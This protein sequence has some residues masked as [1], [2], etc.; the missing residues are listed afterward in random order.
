MYAF[1]VLNNVQEFDMK[2]LS[3][4]LLSDTVISR[5]KALKMTQADL[6]KR[7][8]MNRSM[9]S[10]LE[11][12]DYTPSIDQLQALGECL[13]FEPT[14]LFL[15]SETHPITERKENTAIVTNTVSSKARTTE[16]T[17]PTGSAVATT[18]APGSPYNIAAAGTGSPYNI[19]VAGT[20]YVGLSLAV[21]L[22]QHNSVTAV[23]IIPEKVEKINNFESPI[24]DDYIEKFLRE[25]KKGTRKLNLHAT[26]DGASAYRNADFVIVAAPTNYDPKKNFFDCSA[27]ESVIRL[28]QESTKDNSV[29]H[30]PTIII[31]S[32]IPV[33]Y[34]RHIREKLGAD[35]ILFSPEFLRE[36]KAL[37]D[38]LY[39]SRIIV[40]YDEASDY[41]REKAHTFASLLQQGA[42]KENID[43]LFMGF[44]EAEAT[45]LFV[46]TYLA[47]RV[48]YF[49]E[50]D[51]YAEVKGLDTAQIIK[52]VCLDPRVGDY[53]NNPSFGYGGYCLPKDTKQLLAN[54]QDVPENL[55]EAIVQA[56]R[57]RKDFIADRVLEIAGTYGNSEDYSSAK[58]SQQ[59]DIV[60]GVYRLT[61]KANSDNFRQSSI[62]GVMKRI[63]A[64]GATVVIYE[65]TLENGTTFFGSKVV[66]NLKKF[67]SMCGCIIA[68]RYDPALDDVKDK[69]YTRDLFRR[70]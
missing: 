11:T 24:K 42:Y 21:L 28:V 5:R 35:N 2:K 31:K 69:V 37:Y 53:Y 1:V 7:T 13:G 46:N 19:A 3:I 36:S 43:T 38:N 67:K 30:K 18:A 41:S 47:L 55:I 25:A 54:Y 23:D 9:L 6:A 16:G 70:D 10:K 45:K 4:S 61:M 66:N 50:L 20:G 17:L 59:K 56:N 22:S 12:Q 63:K 8:G 14:E 44:T 29:D 15:D 32:T 60:V 57:T 26:T 62:Q 27:V 34:T 48:S 51:T 58:E 33:G 39:P 68:N 65:P 64:K 52:G 40:G 49:N